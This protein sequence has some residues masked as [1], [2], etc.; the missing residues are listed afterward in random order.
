MFP[1]NGWFNFDEITRDICTSTI[2]L[3]QLDTQLIFEI[4]IKLSKNFVS[5]D[6]GWLVERKIKQTYTQCNAD[7]IERVLRDS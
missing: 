3:A 1:D 6:D 2:G 7:N 4:S 5:I